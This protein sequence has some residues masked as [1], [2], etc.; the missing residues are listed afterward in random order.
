MNSAPPYRIVGL[1]LKSCGLKGALPHELAAL[2]FL[3]A[4]DLR[5]NP[6]LQP[7]LG[8]PEL[9][10]LDMTG[11]MHFTDYERTQAFLAHVAR[12]KS[13]QLM[14]IEKVQLIDKLR[15]AQYHVREAAV[16][17]LGELDF[18]ALMQQSATIFRDADS[19]VRVAALEVL[20]SEESACIAQYAEMLLQMRFEDL[21]KKV[22]SNALRTL[23]KLE[24][25]PVLSKHAT[26]ITSRLHH[27]NGSMR[28]SAVGTLGLLEVIELEKH[29]D[30]VFDMLSD[31]FEDPCY[32]AWVYRFAVREAALSTLVK[33]SAVLDKY[34]LALVD[35]LQSSNTEYRV[36]L[37]RALSNLG[38]GSFSQHASAVIDKLS[39][40]GS[41]EGTAAATVRVA[42]VNAF[43][44]KPAALAEYVSAIL[45][46]FKDT[47]SNVRLA[48]MRAVAQ[49]PLAELEKH[50]A[51]FVDLLDDEYCVSHQ[52]WCSK[53]VRDQAVVTLRKLD[54]AIIQGFGDD[55]VQKVHGK[56]FGLD[57]FVF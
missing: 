51:A 55:V 41:Q 4:L 50:A 32:S 13:R 39:Y 54:G 43:L 46:G 12:S 34:A 30:A 7:P 48:A 26:I 42:A 15:D 47:Y 20:H 37:L 16:R 53:P 2:R 35:K 28:A 33:H 29:A 17:T 19:H 23:Y 52:T 1:S 10:L 14:A 21:D 22:R 25:S 45:C 24:L 18:T 27:S 5:D 36:V 9:G 57:G 40:C 44:D 31:T 56:I 11:Q 49:L 6:E 3:E 38:A 8:L